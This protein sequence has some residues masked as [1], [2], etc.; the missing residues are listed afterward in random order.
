MRRIALSLPFILLAFAAH[1][2]AIDGDWCNDD[3]SH[4]RIDGPKIEL[5]SSKIVEGNYTR[6]EFTYI[7]PE[8]EWE[9]GV[10]VR[11]RQSSEELMRRMRK[12]DV[13]PEHSD[14]W[15]RCQRTS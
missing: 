4:V 6:H 2:D 15:R 1:A 7:V 11:F 8:G 10:E 14:L 13:M 12:P 3:G 5:N 9:A